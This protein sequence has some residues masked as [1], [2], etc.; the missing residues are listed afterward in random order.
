MCRPTCFPGRPASPHIKQGL[1]SRKEVS[2]E[3]RLLFHCR[4]CRDSTTKGAEDI[5]GAQS[6]HPWGPSEHPFMLWSSGPLGSP[7]RWAFPSLIRKEPGCRRCK[8]LPHRGKPQG[9]PSHQTRGLPLKSPHLS[10]EGCGRAVT[11][12]SLEVTP[13]LAGQP[14]SS[15]RYRTSSSFSQ[16]GRWRSSVAEAGRCPHLAA[17]WPRLFPKGQ[18]HSLSGLRLAPF[19]HPSA[20]APSVRKIQGSFPSRGAPG[21]GL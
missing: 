11:A 3:V 15:P 12:R 5:V 1:S 13:E 18:A 7:S 10:Q 20:E 9:R 19:S 6:G 4:Q 2:R 14:A 16:D 8:N 17:T 21:L